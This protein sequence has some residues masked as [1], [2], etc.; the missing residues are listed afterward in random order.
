MLNDTISASEMT[1]F[2]IKPWIFD[3]LVIA[4]HLPDVSKY[5]ASKLFSG[6]RPFRFLK[7]EG[8]RKHYL[9]FASPNILIKGLQTLP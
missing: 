9:R 7:P 5:C 4:D 2:Y 8:S 6:V 3:I 1:H